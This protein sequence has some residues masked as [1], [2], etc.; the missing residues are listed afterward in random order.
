MEN[1]RRK[2]IEHI[3]KNLSK[4]YNKDSLKYA[5]IGQ[6]YSKLEVDDT[7]KIANREFEEKKLK[8]SKEKEKP[9]IK[10]EL[11][12]VD[13]KLIKITTRKPKKGFFNKF[14]S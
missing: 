2:L 6:G 9:K 12:D 10:Y 13:N 14:F 3:K 8:T 1:Q 11:Y 7:L 4:G 5:L